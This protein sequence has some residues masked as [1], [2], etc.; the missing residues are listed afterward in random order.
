[1]SDLLE[2]PTAVLV[3]YNLAS[4]AGAEEKRVADPAGVVGEKGVVPC[5]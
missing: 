5:E 4:S 1:M 3:L 2:Q